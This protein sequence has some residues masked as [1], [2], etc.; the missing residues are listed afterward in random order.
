[1]NVGSGVVVGGALLVVTTSADKDPADEF[2]STASAIVL[3]AKLVAVA[4][5]SAAAKG[6][7]DFWSPG[8]ATV[9]IIGG[10]AA[11]SA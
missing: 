3:R 11:V 2:E 1:M 10:G 6:L 5:I 8:A 7:K 4:A 9:T